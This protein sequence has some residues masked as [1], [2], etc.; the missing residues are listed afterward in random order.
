MR[1]TLLFLL[2]FGPAITNAQYT[3]YFTGNPADVQVQPS[4]GVVLMGGAT[5]NDNAMRWFLQ[6][7]N[8]GDVVVIRTSGSNG[9]NDYLYSQLGITVNSV[10]TLVLPSRA[11]ATN[12]YVRTKLNQAEAIW[13]AGGDQSTYNDFW[14]NTAVD[15]AVNKLMNVTKGV[16]GGTSA[17]MAILGGFYFYAG[18]GSVSSATAL[19]NPYG[20][21]VTIG[22]DD[23]LHS[24]FLDT[25]I[26]DTH[27][28]N[29]DRRGRLMVFMARIM[30]DHPSMM[31]K[32][33][34]CE[35]YT[36]V[37]IDSS[38]LGKVFGNYPT[39]N[40]IAYFIQVNCE[41][42]IRGP[43]IC[44]PGA[45]L[46]WNRS[47][48]ALK[49]YAVPGTQTGT[50]SFNVA[51]F[52][53]GSGGS[54]QNWSVTDQTFGSVASNAPQCSV[55]GMKLQGFSLT[56]VEADVLLKWQTTEEINSSFFMI[57]RSTNGKDFTT[58]GQVPASIHS[59]AVKTYGYTDPGVTSLRSK[60]VYYRL[61]LV[62]RDGHTEFSPVKMIQL[63][64][65]ASGISIFPNPATY[66]TTFYTENAA[67]G[68]GVNIYSA[69]GKRVY[70][71]ILKGPVFSL[72][73]GGFSKGIYFVKIGNLT[74]SF[75]KP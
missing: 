69:L 14:K 9:Y 63:N 75:I 50:H 12:S 48:S 11:A 43:E 5:E 60:V 1:L 45:P 15:S 62:D 47:A 51:G 26:T 32:A 44:L 34:A 57:Q 30:A 72:P 36:A 66:Y 3:S 64:G 27:F 53:N 28:D 49:V 24:P 55:L 42:A 41:N 29:P 46:E 23:F 6:K 4:Q 21:S 10:E 39:N 73:V 58:V 22:H 61:Q 65:N 31:P 74:G 17:G 16:V 68:E 70:S 13:I 2:L 52:N 35:E 7:A 37:C 19:L 67:K 56:R 33:I 20:P 71:G 38:G 8:G 54:W 18:N 40:D 59:T 25:L